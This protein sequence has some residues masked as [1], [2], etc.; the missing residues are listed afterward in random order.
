MI[1]QI[2]ICRAMTPERK[3]AC[4]SNIDNEQVMTRSRCSSLNLELLTL[5]RLE[6]TTALASLLSLA[7]V[8]ATSCHVKPVGVDETVLSEGRDIEVGAGPGVDVQDVHRVNLLERAALGLNHEEVDDEE[9]SETAGSE[10]Q[11]VEVVDL[12]RDQGREERD[13]EVE[14]PVGSGRESHAKSAVAG[15]ELV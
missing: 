2:V 11:A 1:L 13:Q 12:A 14:Q 8:P 15:R 10:D 6:N 4:Q 9:E 3:V 7:E 5:S